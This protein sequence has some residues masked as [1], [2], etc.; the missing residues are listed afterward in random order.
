MTAESRAADVVVVGAGVAGSV[1]ASRLVRCGASVLVLESGAD[2]PVPQSTWPDPAAGATLPVD[3]APSAGRYPVGRGPGGGSRINGLLLSLGAADD[4][5]GWDGGWDGVRDRF[6]SLGVPAD[7]AVDEEWGAVDRILAAQLA[8]LGVR[9]D[10]AWWRAGGPEGWGAAGHAWSRSARTT[11]WRGMAAGANLRTA[12][13]VARIALVDGRATGVVLRDGTD[14]RAGAVVLC[15]GAAA[16]PALLAASGLAVRGAP[17]DHPAVAID[18]RPSRPVA[19]AV[20][21]AASA[22]LS[23]RAP[24]DLLVSSWTSEDGSAGALL[25]AAAVR[26]PLGSVR[27]DGR[28]SVAVDDRHLEVLDAGVRLALAAVRSG[29]A[30]GALVDAPCDGW[31]TSVDGLRAASSSQ[32][33]E[34]IR[35]RIRGHWHLACTASGAVDARGAVD[36]AERLWVADAS[37]LPSLPGAGPMAS[38]MAQAS[39]VAGD[40]AG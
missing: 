28:P 27:A 9:R 21:C 25:V 16:S 10:D 38:V 5:L 33:R 6:D 40:V 2:D 11:S 32:R 1:V 37:G 20:H 22:R 14:V 39:L 3:G 29:I 26:G 12:S 18:V 8:T 30:D 17:H 31:S 7:A 4:Y 35:R 19:A 23:V 36:G 15:A 34:W 24:G 13:P